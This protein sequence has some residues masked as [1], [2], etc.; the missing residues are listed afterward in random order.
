MARPDPYWTDGRGNRL[1]KKPC[2]RCGAN[3]G[4]IPLR[5]S[6]CDNCLV[7]PGCSTAQPIREYSQRHTRPIRFCTS[8]TSSSLAP[9]YPR[10]VC[11]SNV[12]MSCGS[13]TSSR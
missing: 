6:I 7:S 10:M 3:V 11:H 2:P 8:L 13:G 12:P 4:P 5:V 1:P 9:M